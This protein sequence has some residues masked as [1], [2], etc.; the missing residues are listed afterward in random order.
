MASHS[1]VTSGALIIPPAR[2]GSGAI[3]DALL[4]AISS[5]LKLDDAISDYLQDK[6]LLTT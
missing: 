4:D 5:W 2:A 1:S 3:Q 6:V